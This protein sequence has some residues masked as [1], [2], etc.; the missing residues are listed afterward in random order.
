MHL[1][2]KFFEL[3]S[4]LHLE[5]TSRIS[6]PP[7]T[8]LYNVPYI[9]QFAS[10]EYAEIVLKGEVSAALDPKWPETGAIST[11]EYV[12]WVTTICGMACTVM[13]LEFFN[14]TK[15]QPISLAR[16]AKEHNV[17]QL[18]QHELS[19]LRYKE[20]CTW[21]EQYN[22]H[23]SLYSRLSIAGIHYLL[24]RGKLVIASVNPNIRGVNTVSK[25]QVGGHLVL[26]VGCDK[27]N[28]TITIHNPSGF[29]SNQSQTFHTISIQNFK[30]H[31][32]G[33]GISVTNSL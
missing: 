2:R 17:Y 32:A 24:A 14:Q 31:F 8:I 25:E 19:G 3:L 26:I 15:H 29:A 10:S 12:T 9:S 13:A 28:S 23:A 6:L 1:P 11:E 27:I 18:H 30:D 33:R 20:Y 7:P 22:L 4:N 16:N 21:V 5:I